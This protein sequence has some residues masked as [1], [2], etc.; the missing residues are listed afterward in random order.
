[1]EILLLLAV[2]YA[3]ARGIEKLTGA[4]DRRHDSAG[5]RATVEKVAASGPSKTTAAPGPAEPGGTFSAAAPRS[6]RLGGKAAAIPAAG[7][8][9]GATMWRAFKEGYTTAWPEAR[10]RHRQRMTERAEHRRL[11]RQ[12]K[13]T[14]RKA[15]EAVAAAP[16]K[17]GYPPPPPFPPPA[18]EKRRRPPEPGF[19]YPY[20]DTEH[21][22]ARPK[23]RRDPEDWDDWGDRREPAE[24][25][26]W[27]DPLADPPAE[28]QR[29]PGNP[30]HVIT[31]APERTEADRERERAE[32]A[33]QKAEEARKDAEAARKQAATDKVL[34]AQKEAREAKER[35][36]AAE[37]RR[38]AAEQRAAE[39][40]KEAQRPRLTVVPDQPPAAQ[41]GDAVPS[42][43]TLIPEIRTLDGLLN[44]YAV[45][46]AMC[47]MRA[48]EAEA[49][50]AD[51]RM[52]SNRLDQFEAQLADLEVDDATR[53]EIAEL[54]DLIATQS[55]TAATYAGDAVD[56]AGIATAVAAAAHKAHGGIAEAVQ[57]SPIEVAAQRG[58]YE[59]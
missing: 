52:L 43:S 23:S 57:S 25:G 35:A 55:K 50:A 36:A 1:M 20:D 21:S 31:T 37:A 42:P 17:P 54:R 5:A 56:S 40:Q 10:A 41:N 33:E 45:T 34:A 19:P 11:E 28:D 47:Q 8:E 51:D 49:I 15:A 9:T 29:R 2:A 46:S 6:S 48:E 16:P 30:V 22:P 3:G 18:A 26:K 58:Y 14:A 59:R 4:P 39:A 38:E 13:E 53:V 27:V 24:P 32:A 44:A 12:E 7:V